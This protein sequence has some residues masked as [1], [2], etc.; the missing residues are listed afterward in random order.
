MGWLACVLIFYPHLYNRFT[1]CLKLFLFFSFLFFFSS[2]LIYN[3]DTVLV[4]PLF[5]L[6]QSIIVLIKNYY[7]TTRTNTWGRNRR[8]LLQEVRRS[9]SLSLSASCHWCVRINFLASDLGPWLYLFYSI[10]LRSRYTLQ[11][12]L[13]FILEWILYNKLNNHHGC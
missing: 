11:Q 6:S 5:F 7:G 3:W 8:H 13:F 1:P 4:V 10:L 2:S 12:I 9:F